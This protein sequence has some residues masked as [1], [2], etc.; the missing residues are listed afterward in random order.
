MFFSD[1]RTR[2]DLVV[3]PVDGAWSV[4]MGTVGTERGTTVLP[5]Q[6]AFE[7]QLHDL[8]SELRERGRTDDPV[9]RQRLAQAWIGLQLNRH[10]NARMLTPSRARRHPRPGGVA[11]E[12]VLV[13][14]APRPRRAR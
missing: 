10:N 9:V 4:V 14:L 8:V 3:G 13:A 7:Q 12:A 6:A 1:A 11:V 2:A 5:Y